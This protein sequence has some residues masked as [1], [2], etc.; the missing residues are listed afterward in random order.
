MPYVRQDRLNGKR[1]AVH[2]AVAAP[3]L[4]IGHHTFDVAVFA[5]S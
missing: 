4:S 5:L 1:V 2:G 3:S